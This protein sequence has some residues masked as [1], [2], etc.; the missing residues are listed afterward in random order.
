ML[1]ALIFDDF[2]F[3]AMGTAC[4]LHLGAAEPGCLAAAAEA[5]ID[6]V[7]RIEARYSRYRDDSLIAEINRAA[8]E[9]GSIELDAEAAFFVD[10]AKLA[11]ERSDGLFDI[12]SGL[13]RRVWGRARDRLP[14]E[15][16]VAALLPRIGMDK[17]DWRPPRLA[18]AVAGMELDLGGIGKEYAADRAAALCREHGATSGYVDLGGDLAIVGPRPDGAPWRIGIRDPLD[19]A[20]HVATMVL[21]TGGIATSGDYERNIDI[22]GRRYGHL[23]DPRTGWPVAGLVSA[24]VAASSALVA[25]TL[26]TVAVLKG[27]EGVA[28]L[29]QCGQP[30]VAIDGDGR[31]MTGGPAPTG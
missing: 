26:A 16:E 29:R 1:P 3:V 31:V 28:W 6:E 24:S 21:G 11:F 17:L 20:Q 25:G 4:R 2:E 9:G 13:L 23:M 10:Y 14:S 27:Y 12:T 22:G 30:F 7:L 19:P 15:A 5:C 8:G 18:F